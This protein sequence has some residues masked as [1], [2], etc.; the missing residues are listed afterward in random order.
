MTQPTP[1]LL[2]AQ[3]AAVLSAEDAAAASATA[4]TRAEIAAIV[5]LAL[6][7]WNEDEETQQKVRVVIGDRVAKLKLPN[8]RRLLIDAF[9]EALRLGVAHGRRQ[10]G[11]GIKIKSRALPA[12]IRRAADVEVDFSRALTALRT[13]DTLPR[14]Q[15]A[16][17][18]LEG[19][20]AAVERAARW[21]VNRAE[22][23]GVEAVAEEVGAGRLWIAERDACLHCTAYAGFIADAGMP[24][25]GGLSFA[26]RPLS[27]DPV[28]NPPLHP[29]CRCRISVWRHEWSRAYP[30]ALKRE[31]RRSVVRG[32]SLPTESERAR[33]RAA[34]ALLDK[35]ARLPKTVEA[36]G[37]RAVK[38]GKFPTRV[39]PG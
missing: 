2:D 34:Q 22:S 12:E 5:A 37:R 10:L 28:P 20:P 1:T 11:S 18:L 26:E 19:A 14:L 33:L 3:G 38:R 16:L 23:T 13:A 27:R 21:G 25:P 7:M 8:H 17:S 36:Y 35:G 30:E 31:A 29:N 9:D 6:S 24:F 15:A 39:F 4:Q 32:F